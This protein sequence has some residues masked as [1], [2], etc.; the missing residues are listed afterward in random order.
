MAA[1]PQLAPAAVST[2]SL[3]RGTL[4]P[5]VDPAAVAV[6]IQEVTRGMLGNGTDIDAD[7]P[8]MDVGINSMNAVLFRFLVLLFVV[9]IL[10]VF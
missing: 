10:L 3:A 8:L 7:M 1:A 5:A 2:A 6:K 9:V 4:A